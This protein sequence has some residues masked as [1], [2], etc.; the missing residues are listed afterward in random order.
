[1]ASYKQLATEVVLDPTSNFARVKIIY[2]LGKKY[3]DN[4][5]S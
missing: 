2:L 4:L 5:S 1:V 3:L